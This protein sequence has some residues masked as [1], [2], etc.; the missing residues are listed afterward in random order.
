MRSL[1]RLARHDLVALADDGL[2]VSP[3]LLGTVMAKFCVAFE[4]VCTFPRVDAA[5]GLA[6]IVELLAH[7]TEFTEPLYLRHNEKKAL[8]TINTSST[9]RFP[10]MDGKKK[11]K[12]KTGARP[13]SPR[14]RPL[15]PCRARARD[16]D[17]SRLTARARARR[18][19]RWPQRR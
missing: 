19:R 11:S 2:G 16:A 17:G 13:P 6:G 1:Q 9:I 10:L 12:I 14:R 5:T 7:A 8:F 4:T 18:R 15:L 3:R